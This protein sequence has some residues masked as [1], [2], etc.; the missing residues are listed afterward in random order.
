MKH[1]DFWMRDLVPV[2][3]EVIESGGEFRLFPR[4]ASMLP[5]LREGRNS[6]ALVKKGELSVG[7][8]CLYRRENGQF[9][10]HRIVGRAADGTLDFCGDNQSEIE[11]GIREEQVIAVVTAYYRGEKRI[12]VRSVR[13]S[14]YQ[15]AHVA[16]IRRALLDTRKKIFKKNR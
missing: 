4:G 5:L 13:H 11:H 10:L 6:V 15:K 7:D 1:A 3:V 16:K 14:L 8:I 9:V 12:S 2:L